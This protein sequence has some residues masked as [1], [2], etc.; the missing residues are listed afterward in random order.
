MDYHQIIAHFKWMEFREVNGH[1]LVNCVDFQNLLL[2]ALK[3][4]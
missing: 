4:R 1:D 3:K 2:L